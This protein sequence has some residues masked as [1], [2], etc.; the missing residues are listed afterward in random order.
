[1]QGVVCKV[2]CLRCY[3]QGPCC[4]QGAMCKVFLVVNIEARDY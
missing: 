2:L 3:V 4:V 1:V